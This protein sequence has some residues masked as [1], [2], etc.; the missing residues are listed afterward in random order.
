MELLKTFA[1]LCLPLIAGAMVPPEKVFPVVMAG[2]LVV[3]LSM[4]FYEA[5]SK[6]KS[7]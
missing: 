4:D 3:L 1:I 6:K 5:W 2:F 7:A